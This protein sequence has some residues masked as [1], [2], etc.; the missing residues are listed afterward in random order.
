MAK[1]GGGHSNP[2]F[3]NDHHKS[4]ANHAHKYNLE[5]TEKGKSSHDDAN[6]YNPYQHRNVSNPT[7]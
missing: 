2:A 7:T 1:H 6:D 5:M 3:V 4:E